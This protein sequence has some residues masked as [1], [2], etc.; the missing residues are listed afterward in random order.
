MA[1]PDNIEING[2]T[3]KKLGNIKGAGWTTGSGAPTTNG[4]I[5]GDLYL[6]KDTGKVYLWSNSSWTENGN[7]KGKDGATGTGWTSGSNTPA[8]NVGRAN[9]F[10]LNTSNGDVYR[11]NDSGTYVKVTNITGPQGPKGPQGPQGPQGGAGPQ[12]PQG[13]AGPQG[14]RGY[15]GEKG[16]GWTSGSNTPSFNVGRANEFYLNTSNGDVYRSNNSGAYEK[17]GNIK[18]PQGSQGPRGPQGPTGDRGPQG[19]SG[20]AVGSGT[21]DL[22]SSSNGIKFN[23]SS[24]YVTNMESGSVDVSLGASSGNEASKNVSFHGGSKGSGSWHVV[25]Q[26]DGV[27]SDNV[28]VGI[29]SISNSGFSIWV[30]NVISASKRTLR[31]HYIAVKYY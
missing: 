1:S 19:P 8:F 31:L 12:G 16:T 28:S 17:V 2:N 15:T 30:K 20:S 24:Y 10:Y 29:T 26:A 7:I 3:Y 22:S 18:G 21:L 23:T 4:V 13:G 5:E 9:E 6:D 25:A 14:P 27:L 11:S